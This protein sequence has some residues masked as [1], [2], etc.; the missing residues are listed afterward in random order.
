MGASRIWDGVQLKHRLVKYFKE[1]LCPQGKI[2]LENL[3]VDP[4]YKGHTKE[5][6]TIYDILIEELRERGIEPYEGV[7][8][9]DNPETDI[10]PAH[11]RGFKTIQ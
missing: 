3:S 10:N 7:M 6:G 11:E 1:I 4:K 8:V 5:A 9:G 2:N